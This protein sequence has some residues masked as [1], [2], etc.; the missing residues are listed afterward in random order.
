MIRE[1]P[2]VRHQAVMQSLI[3]EIKSTRGRPYESISPINRR[4]P[5]LDTL[6]GLRLKRQT[7]TRRYVGG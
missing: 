5:L 6:L 7:E 1:R 3:L 4:L 2:D